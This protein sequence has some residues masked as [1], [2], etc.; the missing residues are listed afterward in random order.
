MYKNCIKQKKQCIH[1]KFYSFSFKK[2]I[3][4][5]LQIFAHVHACMRA[6]LRNS[7]YLSEW[8]QICFEEWKVSYESNL[9]IYL[10]G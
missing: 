2:L 9:C 6:S 3:F 10:R 1:Q 8:N 5:Q 4:A 7:G